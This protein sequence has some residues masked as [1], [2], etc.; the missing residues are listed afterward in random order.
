MPGTCTKKTPL[1]GRS[2]IESVAGTDS[3]QPRR[4]ELAFA[5]WELARARGVGRGCTV[6]FVGGA[7][8]PVGLAPYGR[9]NR[10]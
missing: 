7:I 1:K 6:A 2:R 10:K 8:R 5:D 9:S 3:I 4:P